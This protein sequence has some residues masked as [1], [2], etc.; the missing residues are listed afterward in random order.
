ILTSRPEFS[1]PWKLNGKVSA[2]RLARLAPDQTK[3]MA[4]HVAHGKAMPAEVLDQ[5]AARTEG[6]PLFVEEVTKV[7]LELGV[8][9]EREDRFEASGPL[10]PDLIPTTVQGSLNARLDRLGPA[11][12]TAQL[13]AMIGR[14]FSF[15]L[16]SAVAET[17]EAE[18]RSGLDRLRG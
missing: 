18:L 8:L 15:S 14:E 12:A 9:V 10:P 3:A 4:I 6:I 5:I 13:A 2:M 11:K 1:P 7:V 17:D 16:L